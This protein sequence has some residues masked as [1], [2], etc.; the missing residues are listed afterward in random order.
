MKTIVQKLWTEPAVAIGA[1]ASIIL[2]LLNVAND[3][4]WDAQSIIAIAAP[5]VASLGIRQ[6]VTPTPTT[7]EPK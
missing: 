5:F 3:Q 6:A 1:T 4:I 7:E 2:L